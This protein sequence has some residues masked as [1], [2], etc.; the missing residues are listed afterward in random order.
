[1]FI[2]FKALK[3][4]AA[5]SQLAC[6]A[7][8]PSEKAHHWIVGVISCEFCHVPGFQGSQAFAAVSQLPAALWLPEKQT[9]LFWG[10]QGNT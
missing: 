2:D 6:G 4:F 5:V 7:S 1:M 9:P 8:A 3:P 10:K